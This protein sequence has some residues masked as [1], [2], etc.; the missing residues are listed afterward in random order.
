MSRRRSVAEVPE[1]GGLSVSA[2]ENALLDAGL[3]PL[4]VSSG[5]GVAGASRQDGAVVRGQDPRPHARMVMGSRVCFWCATDG[6]DPPGR[7]GGGGSRLPRG[8]RPLT[9]T[10]SKPLR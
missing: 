4:C 3:L 7:G 10:G 2:A 5:S 8:P 6:D 1:L 9:P